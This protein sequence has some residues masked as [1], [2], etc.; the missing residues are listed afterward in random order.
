M[1]V[2]VPS[3]PF[4][5]IFKGKN[6]LNIQ[7]ENFKPIKIKNINVKP[8]VGGLHSTTEEVK[9]SYELGYNGKPLIYGE[10]SEDFELMNIDI[11][12]FYVNICIKLTKKLNLTK[13]GDVLL[14]L[15]EQRLKYKKN[16][17]T[18]TL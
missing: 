2:R 11:Q 4:Y 6:L 16:K 7:T 13:E 5:N 18:L 15:N 8:S 9:K 14:N 17:K 10:E 12:S 3:A 1:R